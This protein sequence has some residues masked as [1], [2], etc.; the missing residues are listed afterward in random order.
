MKISKHPGLIVREERPVNAEAPLAL[1][2][3]DFVTPAGLFFVRNHGAVPDVDL[4]RYRLSVTGMITRPLSLSLAEIR[5]TFP[6]M[7][8]TAALQCA[9]NRRN[10]LLAIAP[11]PNEVPWGAGAIG[12]AQWA[13]VPLREIL[14]AAGL[15]AEAAHAAFTGLDETEGN[16]ARFGFGGSIPIAK[17]MS[18]EVVLA[19]EM[20]GEP[21]PPVH[22]FP[23]RVVAP[24]Y[25]GARSVK[26][27]AE[28]AVQSQPSANYFQAHAYKIF[29]PHVHAENVDWASGL[30]LGELSINAVICRPAEGETLRP[31]RILVQGYAIA[32]GGRSVERVDLSTDDGEAWV[33]ARLLGGPDPWSWRFWEAELDLEPGAACLAARAWDSAAQTQPEDARKIWNFKGYAHNAWHRV[34]VKIGV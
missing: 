27:L 9:G 13:G 22:G 10:D 7:T 6:K 31:G 29:P 1:L 32:G 16:G 11:I 33:T 25:I 28:I 18:G 21:L 17:A 30:M 34:N 14:L 15:E 2:R 20:N 3:Q 8:V 19:Y 23:L 5:S 12:N 4:S 24:G 26:W